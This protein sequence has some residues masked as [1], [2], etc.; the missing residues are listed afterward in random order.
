MAWHN[1][2]RGG[3]VRLL[4][5]LWDWAKDLELKPEDLRKEVWLSKDNSQKMARD[6]TEA[7]RHT[8]VLKK[9]WDSAKYCS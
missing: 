1:A 2:A 8:E 9:L 3:H 4:E 6:I 7:E 5:K